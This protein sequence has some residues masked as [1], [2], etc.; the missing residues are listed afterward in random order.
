MCMSRHCTL[1]MFQPE[2]PEYDVYLHALFRFEPR[3]AW[4]RLHEHVA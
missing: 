3:L 4:F 2:E 1:C